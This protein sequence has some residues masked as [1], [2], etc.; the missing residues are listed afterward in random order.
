MSPLDDILSKIE[1]Q[2]KL[3]RDDIRRK[4]EAKKKD[5]LDMVS[6]EGAAHLVAK[7]LGVNMANSEKRKLDIVNILPGMR[8]VTAAG[9]VFKTSNIVNFKKSSGADGRVVNLFVGDRTGFVRVALWN[10]QVSIMEDELVKLG[11]IVQISGA[12][13]RE[14]IYGDIEL[15]LGKFGRIF[16]INEEAAAEGI[17][18]PTTTELTKVFAGPRKSR[19]P[20]KNIS[21]GLFEIRGIVVDVIRGN[22]IFNTCPECGGKLSE[23]DGKYT[24]GQHGEV[25]PKPE[26]VVSFMAD[27]GT[28]ALRIV[29]FRDLA[30]RLTT[31]KA[32]ELSRL[33]LDERYKTVSGSILGKE[34]IIHGNVKKNRSFDRLEMIADN[35]QNLNI[36]EESER[37][38]ELL[39]MKLG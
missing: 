22:F 37:L 28:G 2:T 4:I 16:Q 19:V 35:V 11:D 7:E 12:F 17:D 1:G 15:S 10:E 13:A 21:A 38:A 34:F 14:N 5:L 23:S 29:A 8:N 27:D 24:C 25:K 31:T 9:R 20:I 26:M 30:E 3:T 6:D 39:K 18:F 36:S 33:S 32:S